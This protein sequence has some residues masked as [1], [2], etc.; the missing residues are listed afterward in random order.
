MRYAVTRQSGGIVIT[1]ALIAAVSIGLVAAARGNKWWWD[2]LSGPDSSNFVGSDQI[3]KSNV[4]QLEVAWFY[5]YAT[6][7]FNPIVVD[8]VMY[9][10]GRSGS[11]I[12]L[13]ATTGNEIWIHEG[14]S[15]ITSRGVNFWQ[16][17]DGKDKRLLFCITLARPTNGFSSR[18]ANPSSPSARTAPSICDTDWRGPSNMPEGFNR[19]VP[20]R[21]GRTSSSL[22]RRPARLL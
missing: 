15:G 12:A 19:T 20:A 6:A 18:P 11:L 16:S 8:D 22:D 17:E 9:L 21:Y 7:G 10:L 2:N 4:S 1:T 3:K 5:P 13:D 14:L